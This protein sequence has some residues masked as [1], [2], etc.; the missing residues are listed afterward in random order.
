VVEVESARY[1]LHRFVSPPIEV[2]AD[3]SAS[4]LAGW[5]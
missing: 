3:G 1:T 5:R 2:Q 4:A